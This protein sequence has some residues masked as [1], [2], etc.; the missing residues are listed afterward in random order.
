MTPTGD[1]AQRPAKAMRS[2]EMIHKAWTNKATRK[3]LPPQLLLRRRLDAKCPKKSRAARLWRID[4]RKKSRETQLMASRTEQQ[5]Q[6]LSIN[7]IPMVMVEDLELM[8]SM[9]AK[10]ISLLLSGMDDNS[11]AGKPVASTLRRHMSETELLIEPNSLR[12]V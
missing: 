4:T 10:E 3:I 8:T 5:A 2:P 6:Q 11:I 1:T 7:N 9:D 12:E